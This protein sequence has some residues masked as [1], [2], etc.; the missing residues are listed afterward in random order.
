MVE[1]SWVRFSCPR[2][3][4]TVLRGVLLRASVLTHSAISHPTVCHK[5]APL[6]EQWVDEGAAASLPWLRVPKDLDP[7][8]APPALPHM[9]PGRQ[10]LATSEQAATEN[11]APSTAF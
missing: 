6:L 8:F 9:A 11:G 4:L 7:H 2:S 1:P 3:A 10:Q 5:R